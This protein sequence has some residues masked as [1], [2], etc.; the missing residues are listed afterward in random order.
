VAFPT[1]ASCSYAVLR[2]PTMTSELGSF[3]MLKRIDICHAS[4]RM[5]V[6]LVLAS[7]SASWRKDAR[8]P[9]NHVRITNVATCATDPN[10]DTDFRVPVDQQIVSGTRIR[11]LVM[12]T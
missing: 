8:L 11:S 12:V 6:P 5:V 2:M 3:P 1:R 7:F 10:V 9:D 4:S